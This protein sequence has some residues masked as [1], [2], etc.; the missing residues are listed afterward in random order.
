MNAN[1]I[2]CGALKGDLYDSEGALQMTRRTGKDWRNLMDRY[3]FGISGVFGAEY[4][5]LMD[6]LIL[7]DRFTFLCN[8]VDAHDHTGLEELRRIVPNV[9]NGL[10]RLYREFKND[11]LANLD[12]QYSFHTISHMCDAIVLLGSLPDQSTDQFEHVHCFLKFIFVECT[13]HSHDSESLFVQMM[14]AIAKRRCRPTT[15][16]ALRAQP[17]PQIFAT[18]KLVSV[19]QTGAL[20]TFVDDANLQLQD[21]SRP[22]VSTSHSLAS[23]SYLAIAPAPNRR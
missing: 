21:M 10:L 7:W 17:G 15:T 4:T 23:F 6:L 12:R 2:L 18:P 22:M 1:L 20:R 5:W 14:R 19:G 13:N 16:I 8:T 3:R 11:P 9:Q